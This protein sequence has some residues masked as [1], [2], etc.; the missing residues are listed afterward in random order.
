MDSASA[1][2]AHERIKFAIMAAFLKHDGEQGAESINMEGFAAVLGR[3]FVLLDRYYFVVF[4]FYG[5]FE[6]FVWDVAV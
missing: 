4:V 5:F 1:K 6:G 3:N 2:G